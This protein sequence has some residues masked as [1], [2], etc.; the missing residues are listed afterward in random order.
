MLTAAPVLPG[1]AGQEWADRGDHPAIEQRGLGAERLRFHAPILSSRGPAHLV[2]PIGILTLV[3]P[4]LRWR[5]VVP[6]KEAHLAKTRLV[7]PS[8]LSRPGLA[9]AMALDTLESVCRALTPGDVI[10]VTSDEVVRHAADSMGAVVVAD[11]GGGLNPAVQAGIGEAVRG[12]TPRSGTADLGVAVLLGDLPALRPGDLLAALAE[13]ARHD[14][15]VVPDLMGTGTVLLTGTRGALPE[16]HFGEG[17]AHRHAEL[18]TVLTPDLPR[19]RQDV[20]DRAG[21]AAA[22]ALGLGPRTT[23]FL[24]Q[25]QDRRAASSAIEKS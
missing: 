13:C 9:R 6:V 17:S 10:T 21:L 2:Q 11:P 18:A 22:T 4:S 14:R 24:A 19:L 16:P 20:D 5:L 12:A 1:H 8:Q 15:A 7:T 25:D 3:T 23:S